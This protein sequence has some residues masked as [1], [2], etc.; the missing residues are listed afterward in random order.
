MTSAVD[1]GTAVVGR[2]PLS[3]RQRR[4]WFLDQWHGGAPGPC[5]IAAVAVPSGFD[6]QAARAAIRSVVSRYRALR[7]SVDVVDGIPMQEV[8]VDG[9]VPVEVI[10]R[11]P[12]GP[13]IAAVLRAQMQRPSGL[14]SGRAVRG[15]VV[16]CAD[17]IEAMALIAHGVVCDRPSAASISRALGEEISRW[18]ATTVSAI[19]NPEPISNPDP[20]TDPGSTSPAAAALAQH[21]MLDGP[22]GE[23]Q[24]VYWHGRL[25]GAPALVELPLDRRRPP[26]QT[27]TAERFRRPLDPGAAASLAALARS[28]GTDASTVGMAAMLTLVHRLSGAGDVVVGSRSVDRMPALAGT[29][30]RAVGPYE[31]LLLLRVA[32]ADDP[33]TRATLD[34][35]RAEVAG[36]R[37]HGAYPFELLVEAFGTARELSHAPVCQVALDVETD[38]SPS[39][40][41]LHSAPI[42]VS[43][44]WSELDLALRIIRR[45]H[46]WLLVVDYATD[47]FDAATV[48]RWCSHLEVLLGAMADSPDA[49]VSTLALLRDSQQRSLLALDDHT[50]CAL[51]A[52][53]FHELFCEQ[54]L[55]HPESVAVVAGSG[56]GCES[57]TYGALAG[58]SAALADHLRSLGAGP[59][60][61]VGICAERSP[62]ML[63]GLLGIVRA[64]A[65][66]VPIDPAFPAQRI[67]WM[68]EDSAAPIVVT[69][70]TL[71]PVLPSHEATLVH[72]DELGAGV[73]RPPVSLDS[74]SLEPGSG[75]SAR[76]AIAPAP[77]TEDLAY[78]IFTSGS[79]GRPKGVQVSHGALTNFLQAMT[80][81]PGL[82]S[83]DVLLAV[84]TLSFDIAALELFGPLLVGA[85]V[86]I[87][88]R[89]EAVDGPALVDLIDRHGV[90]VMQ[91]TPATWRMLID[92]GWAGRPGLRV[93]CGGEALPPVL[94][95]ELLGRGVELWNMYGPTETTIWSSCGRVLSGA[96]ISLGEAIA[97]TRLHVLDRHGAVAPLGVAAELC[98]AGSG[99]ALGY[100]GRPDLTAEKFVDEPQPP[101]GGR[102]R[103]RMYRTGDLVRRRSDATIEFVGRLDHQVK[104][105]GFRI[106]LGEIES[107]LSSHPTLREVVVVARD[108]PAGGQ[109]LV[110]YVV[111][112]PVAIAE[113]T[114]LREFLRERLPAYMI[115]SAFVVLEAFPLTP[116]GKIDRRALPE[117]EPEHRR[118]DDASR[119]TPRSPVEILIGELWSELLGLDRV[120]LDDNF[121]DLG[122]NSIVATRLISRVTARLGV[123]VGIGSLFE[124]PTV[125]GFGL[126]VTE[127]LA[128]ANWADELARLLDDLEGDDLDEGIDADTIDVVRGATP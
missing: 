49:P 27:W 46:E 79:T 111:G 94:A 117:P 64:G 32:F 90:T 19:S 63:V 115:P 126:A 121:F 128:G 56:P 99:V 20:I 18:V 127:H 120:G 71:A 67:A 118:P 22:E 1:A 45:T 87:A 91:A 82:R 58:R 62:E 4:A 69:T 85:T 25:A 21:A 36:A 29:E 43:P 30:P 68:L 28:T 108:D 33:S 9:D 83:N 11:D 73:P 44:P 109:R 72:L 114:A 5:E 100:L 57:L 60:T 125:E 15:V 23:R 101:G 119:A 95:E 104:I 35:V 107:T 52:V 10:D 97:N 6:E 81:R 14:S 2:S 7:T 24:R 123:D 66:Y 51:R 89:A 110:A 50:A 59:G 98:I 13:E 80:D 39:A 31:N 96:P 42:D 53:S 38:E 37:E 112:E 105:R 34:R 65:A 106:E 61:L 74:A 55:A 41:D 102:P 47:L 103:A 3:A 26:A 12:S 124:R 78:T 93:L 17:R 70:S 8:A 116:N 86:V 54:A 75:S 88:S 16:R 76:G 40:D 48:E 92:A 113:V 84:T 77:G 122:G